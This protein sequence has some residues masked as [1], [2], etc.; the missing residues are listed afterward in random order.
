[1]AF[2][3]GAAQQHRVAS[4]ELQRLG[5]GS[6]IFR[7]RVAAHDQRIGAICGVHQLDEAVC[8]IAQA[9]RAAHLQQAMQGRAEGLCSR[10]TRKRTSHY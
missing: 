5:H 10:I 9:N 2:A 1:M 4:G 3:F 6:E 8:R 7:M